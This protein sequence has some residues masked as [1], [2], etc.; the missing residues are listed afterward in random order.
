MSA[1]STAPS[2]RGTAATTGAVEG[3]GPEAESTLLPPSAPSSSPTSSP[4]PP[5]SPSSPP[6]LESEK[7]PPPPPPL[8]ATGGAGAA[9]TKRVVTRCTWAAT[10]T[11]ASHDAS[12]TTGT[13][14][15]AAAEPH[16][17]VQP[18]SSTTLAATGSYG[19][20][21]LGGEARGPS[22][23]CV[24]SARNR[25]TVSVSR[26]PPGLRTRGSSHR[27]QAVSLRANRSSV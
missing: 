15:W 16:A 14:A 6:S 13:Y 9:A 19:P 5:P 11:H 8:P 1:R 27:K 2:C 18:P 17:C 22:S 23:G 24:H 10:P 21:R 4:S 7:S 25:R 20:A 3:R 26:D 12:N